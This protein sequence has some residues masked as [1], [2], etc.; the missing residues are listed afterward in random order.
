V[1]P[2]TRPDGA[3]EPGTR[4][5][6]GFACA[7]DVPPEATWSHTPWQLRAALRT[8]TEVLDLGLD[9]PPLLR[10]GL[11]ALG[12]H[13]DGGRWGTH[14]KQHPVTTSLAGRRLRAA[15]ARLR[16]DVALQ[17]GD[18]ATLDT[19]FLLYQDASYDLLLDRLGEN[20]GPDG[21]AADPAA[22][23]AHFPGLSRTALLR[24]RDRQRE[25]YQRAAGVLA[26]SHWLAEHLVRVSGVP[27]ARVHV[28]PPGANGLPEPIDPA[29]RDGSRHRLLL[30][31]KDFHTKNGELVLAALALLRRDHDPDFELTVVGPRDWPLP[32]PVPEGVRF[33]GRLPLPDVQ[34]LYGTHDLFVMP[35]RFEGYGIALVEALAHGLPCVARQDC[36]MPEIVT[37]GVNGALLSADGDAAELAGLIAA[38]CADERLYQRTAAGAAAVRAEYRWG[39]AAE[40]V[41]RVA[42]AVLG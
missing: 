2:M 7:W 42:A 38:C 8:R 12:A 28:V 26:M 21:A 41:L 3:D 24:L 16:P 30:V 20:G 11:R 37:P 19:P 23:A 35:S 27:A 6:L 29:P 18:L 5:R 14:W 10:R 9:W 40:D 39:R 25:I 31:G 15:E 17:M 32:G 13:R 34:A 36:A 33:R 4:P 1:T 22:R